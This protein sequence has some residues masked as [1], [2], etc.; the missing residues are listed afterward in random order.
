MAITDELREWAVTQLIPKWS[1]RLIAIAN[2]ID[3]QHQKACDDA[4]DNGYEADYLG[5]ENWLIEHQQVMKH[6]GYIELPKDADGEPI[7]IGDVMEWCNGSFTVHELKLT[8]DGWQTWDSEHGY[9]VHADEC[10]RHHHAPTVE[11]VL[12]QFLGECESAQNLG[13][14]EVPQEVLAEY[15]AKLRLAGDDE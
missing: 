12:R 5:I 6:H 7:H 13:Y 10:I 9:A 11:D 1:D 4:W 3:E 8:E 14:D 2:R 15:A